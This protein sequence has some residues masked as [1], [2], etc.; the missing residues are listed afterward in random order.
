M[1]KS[2]L[3]EAALIIAEAA[4]SLTKPKKR[5]PVPEDDRLAAKT[6][7]AKPE[8]AKSGPAKP[9]ADKKP[10]RGKKGEA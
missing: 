10:A 7:S 2:V 1:P 3:D 5:K 9:A 6:A 4:V 8:S